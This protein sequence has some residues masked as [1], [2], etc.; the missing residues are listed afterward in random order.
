MLSEN[1]GLP[2]GFQGPAGAEFD[3]AAGSDPMGRSGPEAQRPL[4]IEHFNAE[5]TFQLQSALKVT[6]VCQKTDIYLNIKG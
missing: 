1:E 2:L 6:S 3:F 4:F 5:L